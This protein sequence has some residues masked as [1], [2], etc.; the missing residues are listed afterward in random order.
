M[1]GLIG[2][3]DGLIRLAVFAGVFAGDGAARAAMAQA[4]ADRVEAEAL[5]HQYRHQRDGH[6]VAQADGDAG[7]ADRGH[8]RR[9]LCASASDRPVEPR[10]LAAMAQGRGGL[11]GARPRHLGAASGLA[12]DPDLLASAPGPS[13]R[14]RHRRDHGGALP[15]GRDRAVDAVEDRGGGAARRVAV[16]GVSVRGDSQRLRHVQ[17]RQYRA[18]G[19][20]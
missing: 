6:L 10:R 16:G 8:R 1:D 12:Q 4:Q 11:A 7:R 20:V 14:P 3:S 13:R 2:Q 5:A 9:V 19:S 18:A 17:P 15:P